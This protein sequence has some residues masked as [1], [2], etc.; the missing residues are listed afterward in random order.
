MVG[1]ASTS[2]PPIVRPSS[3]DAC[4]RRSDGSRPTPEALH[5]ATTVIRRG[6]VLP[7]TMVASDHQV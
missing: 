3:G 2:L 4:D 5:L 7:E 1:L 6:Y